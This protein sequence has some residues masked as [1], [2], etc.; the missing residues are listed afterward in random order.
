ME[1]S[2]SPNS[3]SVSPGGLVEHRPLGSTHLSLRVARSKV[4]PNMFAREL[5]SAGAGVTQ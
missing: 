1:C 2:V 4:G 3:A 5:A